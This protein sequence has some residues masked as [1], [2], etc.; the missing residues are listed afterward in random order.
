MQTHCHWFILPESLKD[1]N[2]PPFS[3]LVFNHKNHLNCYMNFKKKG[4]FQI[5]FKTVAADTQIDQGEK[6]GKQTYRWWLVV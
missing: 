2:I 1:G 6:S 3:V 5:A 4:C